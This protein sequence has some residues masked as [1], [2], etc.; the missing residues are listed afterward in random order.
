MS[1]PNTL[2]LN[3]S[4]LRTDFPG[5]RVV[6]DMNLFAPGT[7]RGSD[8]AIPGRRGQLGN[9]NLPFDAYQFTVSVII[10]AS[11]RGELY[12]RLAS[13]ANAA[14]GTN[15]LVT[16]TRRL[17]SSDDSTTVDYTAAGRFVSGTSMQ[18]WNPTTGHTDLVFIN[19]DGAWRRNSD[20]VLCWP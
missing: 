8:D 9:P 20:G 11:T 6:G 15:G 2:L 3:G 5:V 13:L 12:A 18:L 16:L 14:V 19:L 7:R 4:D 10:S 1:N 17:A